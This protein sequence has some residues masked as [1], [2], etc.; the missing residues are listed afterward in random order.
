MDKVV[1]H[2]VV[3]LS[4]LDHYRRVD[5]KRVFGIICGEERDGMLHIDLCY[6]IPFDESEEG[7][8]FDTSYQNQFYSLF[9]KVH[10]T[11]YILGW[12][13]SG[14]NISDRDPAITE[15]F[16]F[17]L[18]DPLLLIVN[19]NIA[20]NDDVPARVFYTMNNKMV[21]M[22]TIIGGEEVEE[23]GV[24]HLLKN[25]KGKGENRMNEIKNSMK[26]YE[27][28]L[29]EIEE[30]I[31]NMIDGKTHKSEELVLALQDC[32]EEIQSINVSGKEYEGKVFVSSVTKSMVNLQDLERNR[33]KVKEII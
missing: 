6:A 24:I 16:K 9:K 17:Y 32:V 23:V 7:W 15:S 19:V 30:E 8:Y 11:K 21:P 28:K 18:D 4:V 27:Q 20:D 13:H 29:M 2:P 33:K 5:N 31:Q 22:E 10:P 12:Y 1:V 26:I 3:L 14:P 25:I